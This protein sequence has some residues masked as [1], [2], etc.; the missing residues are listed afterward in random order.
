M[1]N[2]R[3]DRA[4][5]IAPDVDSIELFRAVEENFS[6]I[7]EILQLVAASQERALFVARD[8]VLKRRVALRVHLEPD[9]ALRCWFERETG[10]L[11]ALDHPVLRTVHAAGH[12]NAWAYRI[13][14]WVEGE[15]LGD[16]VARG[17]RPIPIVLQLARSLA[18][19]LDYVHTQRIVVRRIVPETVMID[20]TERT[21]VTDM[22]YASALLD[23]ATPPPG[24]A[25]DP[26]IAPE[27]RRGEVGEPGS[28][29]Y[30]AGAILYFAVT[31]SPPASDPDMMESPRAMREAC[32]AA[33]ERVIMRALRTDPLDRY[34]SASEMLDDLHADLGEYDVQ[35]FLTGE[36]GAPLDEPGVWEQRLRRALGDDYELL[37][38]LG[39][40]GFG[41][42]YRV[43]DL[44]LEREVALKVLHPY[45]TTDP[46]VVERFRREARTAAQVI[47]PNI[48]NTYDFGGRGGLL[49]YTMEY[50]RGKNL[51]RL[52]QSEGPQTPERVVRILHEALGA[53]RYAHQRGLVHRDIKPE[54]LLIENSTGTVRIADFGLV[55]AFERSEGFAGA[56]SHSGTPDFAAPEQLLGESVDHRADVYSLSLVA[57]YALT[58]RLPFG[59]GTVEMTMARQAAGQLPELYHLRGKAPESLV[60]VLLRGAARDPGDRY[61]SAEAYDQAL[62][63]AMRPWQGGIRNLFRR[64]SGPS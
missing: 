34:L 55:I 7:L 13:V 5:L 2:H 1:P 14:K 60:R 59:A 18:T 44:E 40:G 29:I 24:M 27:V 20:N 48:T 39:S 41:R 31:G 57:L 43:R 15:S 52:V 30:G 36:H 33:L 12:R 37:E 49:W 28:D 45:L 54:N 35:L 32:P 58:G 63:H 3:R 42:V 4:P 22:R 61:D 56:S 19:V 8:R 17:P 46:A 50:V 51:A 10:L 47:H 62:R 21:Y 38:E 9:T 6:D 26:F 25:E 23:V 53:L 16:A 11:A 64:F